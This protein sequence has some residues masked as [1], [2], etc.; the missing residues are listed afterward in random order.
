[1]EEGGEDLEE[2]GSGKGRG[3]PAGGPHGPNS[4]YSTDEDYDDDDNNDYNNNEDS[5]EDMVGMMQRMGTQEDGQGGA[6]RRKVVNPEG[7]W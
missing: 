2:Q 5:D 7:G 3:R 6:K 4:D 1:M